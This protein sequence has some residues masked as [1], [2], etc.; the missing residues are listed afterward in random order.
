MGLDIVFMDKGVEG[1]PGYEV[2]DTELI[3]E[4]LAGSLQRMRV[5]PRGSSLNACCIQ[6]V[7]GWHGASSM[8]H[9]RHGLLP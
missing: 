8:V 1:L 5:S 6:A 2:N 7:G 3:L 4:G 9:L